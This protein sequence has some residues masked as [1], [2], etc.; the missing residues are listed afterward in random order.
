MLNFLGTTENFAVIENLPYSMTWQFLDAWTGE[1]ISLD[2]VTFSGRILMDEGEGGRQVE[3]DIAK[4]EASNTL[5]VG[6]T[7]LPEGRWPYEVFCASDEGLRERML[8]GYI[9]VVGS[10][11]AHS[12]LDERPTAQRTLSVRLPGDTA[13]A[14]K[15]EWLSSSLAQAAASSAW[16][17]WEKTKA[18]A[19]KLEHADDRLGGLMETAQNAMDRLGQV[20]GLMEGIHNEVGH[21]HEAVQKARDL[22]N[23]GILQGEKGDTPVIGENGCWWISGQDTGIRA[24]GRDGITPHIGANGHW[25]IGEEDTQVRAEGTDG[26]DA[27]FIRRLYISSADE[28]PEEGERGV[29]YYIPNPG[30]G[31]DVYAWVDFPDG[32]SAWTPISESTLQQATVRAHGT[33]RLSTGTILTDGGIVG[34]N[35]AGQLLVREARTDV[36]GTVKLSS[37]KPS[38]ISSGLVGLNARGQLIVP[39][40]TVNQAGAIKVNNTKS[41]ERGAQVQTNKNNLAMVP[42]AGNR[43]YGVVA[44]GTQFPVIPHE[45]PY[46]VSLPI[47]SDDTRLNTAALYGTLTI[48]LHRRGFLRYTSGANSE[49]GLDFATGRYLS[50]D[51]GTGLMSEEYTSAIEGVTD[52]RCRLAVRR[53]GDIVFHD[54]YATPDRGGSVKPGSSFGMSTAGVLNL[55]PASP[56]LLGGVKTGS[57]LSSAADG[58]LNVVLDASFSESSP[59]PA[60]SRAIADWLQGKNYISES[61]L[62][63][64]GYVP[65]S[66]VAQLLEDYQPRM[67]VDDVRPLTQEQYEALPERDANTLYV[68]Y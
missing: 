36:P 65:E 6:C 40:A 25:W 7:G 15:L 31:Y 35:E 30:S 3:M 34:V 57:T 39:E 53:Y 8:S 44:T 62:N 33:V 64:R 61:T 50:F 19:E 14:L 10:L 1:P 46:I 2:G 67:A 42:V 32:E 55:R 45:R 54:S 37:S 9:G 5:V 20:D 29:F 38:L 13:R 49:N 22:L 12:V 68:I 26:M 60:A 56:G 27:D 58:T 23:S 16:E 24:E 11:E 48:N 51:Y 59:R 43:S 52:T 21:A 63:A 66:R 47:A 4:G 28:L 17:A 41:V 18:T